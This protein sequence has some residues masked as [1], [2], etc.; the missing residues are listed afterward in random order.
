MVRLH[1]RHHKTTILRPSE[2]T[3]TCH[4]RGLALGRPPNQGIRARVVGSRLDERIQGC[5]A[6]GRTRCSTAVCAPP[7]PPAMVPRSE[8]STCP[9]HRVHDT[10]NNTI[11]TQI[12]VQHDDHLDEVKHLGHTRRNP[13]FGGLAPIRIEKYPASSDRLKTPW[14]GMGDAFPSS[15]VANERERYRP[16]S[17]SSGR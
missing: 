13:S 6:A 15:T 2:L 7:C 16:R 1:T 17:A 5:F 14:A 8:P 11:C 3:M 12:T 9:R 4:A 10:Y